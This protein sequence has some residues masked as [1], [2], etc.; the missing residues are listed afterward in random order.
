MEIWPTILD[1]GTTPVV[2]LA[3]LWLAA[4]L[5]QRL[6]GTIYIYRRLGEPI[7]ELD[8]MEKRKLLS[9]LGTDP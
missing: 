1:L 7:A 6:P 4:S 3:L 9:V 8:T 2:I 5:G